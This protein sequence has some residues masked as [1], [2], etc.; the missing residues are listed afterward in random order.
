MDDFIKLSLLEEVDTQCLLAMSSFEQMMDLLNDPTT[1]QHKEVWKYLQAFL[2]HSGILGCL[3]FKHGNPA[4]TKLVTDYLKGE[5]DIH[6]DSPIKDRD[7]R[8]SLEHI[9][10]FEIYAANRK[11]SKGIMQMVFDNR[12]GLEFIRPKNWYIKRGLILNEMVF[13]FQ[14]QETTKELAL[15]PII[16]EVRRVFSESEKATARLSILTM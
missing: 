13:I 9:E 16:D 7:G 6:E 8:N 15:L 12:K 4:K 14:K 10:A 3:I 5:L 2:A 11:D 1:K